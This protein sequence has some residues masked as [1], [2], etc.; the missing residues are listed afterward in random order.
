MNER[1]YYE[2]KYKYLINEL[3]NILK[4][5]NVYNDECKNLVRVYHLSI[6]CTIHISNEYFFLS[7]IPF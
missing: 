6:G 2:S 1:I 5:E 3:E 7:V 4:F